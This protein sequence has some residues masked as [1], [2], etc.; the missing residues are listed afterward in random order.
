MTN[1][2]VDDIFKD[3]EHKIKDKLESI[4]PDK[5][6]DHKFHEKKLSEEERLKTKYHKAEES[7]K[8]KYEKEK[9]AL[10]KKENKERYGHEEMP[11]GRVANI[12]RSAYVAVILILVAFIGVDLSFYHGSDDV[13]AGEQAITAATVQPEDEDEDAGEGDEEKATEEEKIVEEVKEEEKILTGKID[14]VI[15]NIYTDVSDKNDDLGYISKIIFT[16]ENGKDKVLMPVVHVYAYD[17]ELHESWQERSRGEYIGT[18]IEPGDRQTGV[19][20]LTAKVFRNL[21]LEKSLRLTLDDSEG[22]FIKSVSEEVTI[23]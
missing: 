19:I 7:L 11:H 14:M 3:F 4:H 16:I 18:S 23:S 2:G 22:G 15:D 12:E 8:H 9:E 17:S 21:D 10:E 5:K 20:E 1:E 6:E 13:Q